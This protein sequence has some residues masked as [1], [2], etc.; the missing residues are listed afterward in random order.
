M[1]N[2]AVPPNEVPA[3][4]KAV[5]VRTN[6]GPSAHRWHTRPAMLPYAWNEN[7]LSPSTMVGVPPLSPAKCSRM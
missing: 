7:S 2:L 3:W 6:P 5:G 4:T 1:R